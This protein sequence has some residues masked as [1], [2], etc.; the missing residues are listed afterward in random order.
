MKS[1]LACALVFLSL[2]GCGAKHIEIK[3]VPVPITVIQPAA[4]AAVKLNDVNWHV[5]TKNN[6]NAFAAQ[7]VKDQ[8]TDNPVFVI[9]STDDYKTL[10]GDFAELKRYIEQQQSIIAYYERATT[11][12]TPTTTANSV[13]STAVADAP[14]QPKLLAYTARNGDT[15]FNISRRFKIDVRQ[16]A[17]INNM[18]LHTRL[19]L[20][21][22]LQLPANSQPALVMLAANS[23]QY[24]N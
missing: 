9:I 12:A 6:I 17:T 20:G 15:L 13:D 7:A 3:T 4:P 22:Q 23:A 14:A 8:G 16:L 10:M 21:Q 1:Q 19:Q 24:H 11:P 2:S 18:T 5:V